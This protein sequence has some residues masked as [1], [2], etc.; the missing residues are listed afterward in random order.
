MIYLN[1]IIGFAGL[2]LVLVAFVFNLLKK[3]KTESK[4]YNMMNLIG[5]LMLVYYSIVLNS[6]PFLILQLMWG[7]AALYNLIKIV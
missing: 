2:S 4:L 7:M 3:I 1:E 6:M 5:S